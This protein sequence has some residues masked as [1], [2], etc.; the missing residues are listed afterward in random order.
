MYELEF[1][2]NLKI[3][4]NISAGQNA[5]SRREKYSKHREE[6]VLDAI[7]FPIVGKKIIVEHSG[8]KKTT[9]KTYKCVFFIYLVYLTIV[10]NEPPG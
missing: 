3:S 5:R 9:Y 6:V 10:T 2:I 7:M 1:G 8:Y 4:R